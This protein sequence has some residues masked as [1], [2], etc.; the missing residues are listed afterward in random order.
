MT[1]QESSHQRGREMGN[2]KK[3]R[4]QERRLKGRL[5]KAQEFQQKAEK[6]LQHSEERLRKRLVRLQR[7]EERLEQ[8]M[9]KQM[10]ALVV[11]PEVAV[12]AAEDKTPQVVGEEVETPL[13]VIPPQPGSEV[14]AKASEP[15]QEIR[16]EEVPSKASQA[17]L[18][19]TLHAREARAVAEAAE[20]AARAAAQRA[21][22]VMARLE[23]SG[24]GRHLAVE[25]SQLQ[26][27]EKSTKDAAEA[28]EFVAREAERLI[29]GEGAA[30]V[31]TEMLLQ[32]PDEHRG[33]PT[34]EEVVQVEEIEDE[35]EHL[36]TVVSMIIAEAAAAAA[37]E[38]EALA[39]ASSAHT[40]DALLAVQEAEK[41]V[42]RIRTAIREG[43]IVGD[44]AE[45]TLCDAEQKLIHVHA[46]LAD[47]EQA[48]KQALN[49][50]MNAEAEAEVAEGMAFAG[51]SQEEGPT[52]VG[53]RGVEET[54]RTER[55][56]RMN[57]EIDLDD[58]IELP[59]IRP[60]E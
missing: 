30:S 21:H 4:K 3:E 34:P 56:E 58:T 18:A 8:I 1:K 59:I 20:E 55:T 60:Q 42:E 44:E 36:E 17:P 12:I 37:A 33:E 14:G 31:D 49:T 15:Q 50:A 41:G 7:L 39:E 40:R 27:E 45:A 52:S 9:V 19:A 48:E 57:G 54:E 22:D 13:V 51:R 11:T 6:R 28:A 10:P 29:E 32:V 43:S 23:R 38:A 25:L 5:Q 26:S 53:A 46:V 47:A 2:A 24:G 16:P 35:E